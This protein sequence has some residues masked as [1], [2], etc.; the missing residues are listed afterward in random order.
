M[1]KNRNLSSEEKIV[2]DSKVEKFLNEEIFNWSI[3]SED[4]DIEVDESIEEKVIKEII[5]VLKNR[6]NYY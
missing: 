5:E 6:I 4:M 1:I 2:I 3:V